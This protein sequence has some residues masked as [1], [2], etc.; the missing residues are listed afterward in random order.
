MKRLKV[1]DC[2]SGYLEKRNSG[3]SSLLNAITDQNAVVV[4][5][6][7]GTTTDPVF[8]A[9]ELLPI[10]PVVLIDTP[11]IDDSGVLTEQRIEK[12]K[13]M[14]PKRFQLDNTQM[15]RE[16]AELKTLLGERK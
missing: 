10:G 11:G 7:K 5:P 8:R 2:I 9:M 16:I 15:V 3:K 4:S 12:V 6:V 13:K 1:K 14:V